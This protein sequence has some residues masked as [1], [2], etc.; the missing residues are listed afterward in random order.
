MALFLGA[1]SDRTALKDEFTD[2][3]AAFHHCVNL[4]EMVGI[5]RPIPFCHRGLQNPCIDKA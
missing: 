3:P 1:I 2:G 4:F 5:D